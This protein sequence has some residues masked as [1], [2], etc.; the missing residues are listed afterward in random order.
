MYGTDALFIGVNNK[1]KERGRFLLY[2]KV[3]IFFLKT[4]QG[5]YIYIYIRR[6]SVNSLLRPIKAN[7]IF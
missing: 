4:L 6:G 7:V 1:R 2:N 5:Q 3:Q